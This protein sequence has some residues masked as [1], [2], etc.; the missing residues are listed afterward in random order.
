MNN[1]QETVDLP[2]PADKPL[3][4]PTDLPE[5]RDLYL[6]GWCFGRLC[7]LP[8][9]AAVGVLVWI[10]SGNLVAAISAP[11]TTGAIGLMVS[12]YFTSRAWDY[13]P[14]KRQLRTGVLRWELLTTIIDAAALFAITAAVI[15][16]SLTL[17]FELG[18]I[19]FAIGAGIAIALIQVAQ[20]AAGSP[21][22]AG[23]PRTGGM[24]V[25]RQQIMLVV[26]A[27]SVVCVSVFATGGGVSSSGLVTVVM[28]AMSVFLAYG[29]W[30]LSETLRAAQGK[31]SHQ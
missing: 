4:H 21:Q 26:V 14:R 5:A 11:V 16:A 17:R 7:S 9:L 30:W 22:E 13:I 15:F 20:L 25:I 18:V 29:I 24:S 3:L 2:D 6:R 23:M 27:V 10:A 31:P 1:M 19:V 12:T 8:V 28:G